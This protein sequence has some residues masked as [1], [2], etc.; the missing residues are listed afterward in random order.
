MKAVSIDTFG[1]EEVLQYREL[2]KPAP[3]KGEVLIRVKAAGV[4][5]VDWKIREGLLKTRL[6]HQFPIILGWDVAGTI[7]A[8]GPGCRRFKKGDAVYAYA[9]KPIIKDGCY[10]EFVALPEKNVAAKPAT[11]DFAQAASIPLA[12]LTAW[13]SLFDAAGL[14]K[15]QTVLIHAAAGGV[16]GFA[17][18]LAKGAG[19]RVLATAS[20]AN[21]EY[22]RGLG[23]DE[24][25]DYTSVDFVEAV[26]SLAPKGVDVA[27][28]TVGGEVQDRSIAVV[29]KG[30]TLVTILAPTPA[31]Q[32]AKGIRLR[33][34]FVAPNAAQ[35]KR[36]AALADAGRLRTHLAA[37]LPLA[38]AA[39]AHRMIRTGHTRG[40]IVLT[41]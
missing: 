8:L 14:K 24:V 13:Q 19:A 26:R 29:R 17:V 3:A 20:A 41:P 2:E 27:Y 22:C 23:A 10:A 7:A 40:K 32:Q 33:Y 15:G 18:Q 5:P 39:E 38:Q 35:L 31:A 30:G 25:I 28:D 4:N 9:R 37:V 36:L 16:G 12:A 21:H 1:G 11:L 6:P 34:V